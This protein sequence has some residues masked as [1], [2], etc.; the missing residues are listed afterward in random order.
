MSKRLLTE[1]TWSVNNDQIMQID[2]KTDHIL[3][4]ALPV[5]VR[6]GFSKTSMADI[7]RA[8]NIS[9]ASLYLT[10][11]S[12]EEL[13]RAGSLRAH[14]RTM[15][16]VTAALA[17]PGAVIDRIEAA[18]AVFQR[19]L[20]TPFGESDAANELFATNMALAADITTEARERLLGMLEQ[21]L[22]AAELSNEISL[23]PARA[24]PAQL[25]SL[26]LAGIEGI[27]H[28][29]RGGPHLEEETALFM[30]FLR[31]AVMPQNGR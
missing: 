5:F 1:W 16:N 21:T 24:T 26:I 17:E 18:M 14:T 12:K 4:A 8:A 7:A 10:F 9:R 27:K 22:T 28:S 6:F 20:I 13:F 11:N 30:R 3:D 31:V 25:A 23:E 29:R 19:E 2:R 15:A